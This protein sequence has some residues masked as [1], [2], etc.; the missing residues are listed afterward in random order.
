MTNGNAVYYDKN[1][2]WPFLVKASSFSFTFSVSSSEMIRATNQA[3][4]DQ[5]ILY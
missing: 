1:V 5:N 2:D 4:Q 3:E